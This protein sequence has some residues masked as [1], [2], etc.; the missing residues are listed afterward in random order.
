VGVVGAAHPAQALEQPVRLENSQAVPM[1]EN[2]PV[3][4]SRS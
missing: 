3:V 2:G 4:K 1:F